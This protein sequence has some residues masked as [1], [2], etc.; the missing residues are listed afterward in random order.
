[1]KIKQLQLSNVVWLP[2]GAGA[3]T[4]TIDQHTG[5][6]QRGAGSKPTAL[7]AQHERGVVLT[8][9]GFDGSVVVPHANIAALVIE[10]EEP[11]QTKK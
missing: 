4:R 1:M 6:S 10:K 3:S 5:A 9:P 7:I 8:Y 2:F 11:A